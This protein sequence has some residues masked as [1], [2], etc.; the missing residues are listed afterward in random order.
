MHRVCMHR[1]SRCGSG[2]GLVPQWWETPAVRKTHGE[3]QPRQRQDGDHNQKQH[4]EGI[5]RGCVLNSNGCL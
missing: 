5:S 1:V 4:D 2:R 3:D